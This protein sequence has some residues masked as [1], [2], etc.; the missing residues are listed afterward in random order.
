MV[1][2]ATLVGHC[3]VDSVLP[4]Q[5]FHGE[6]LRIDTFFK[7]QELVDRLVFKSADVINLVELGKPHNF[8]L[9]V[10]QSVCFVTPVGLV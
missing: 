10:G 3:R 4:E 2:K 8:I 9:T 5:V 7:I 1:F 6:V